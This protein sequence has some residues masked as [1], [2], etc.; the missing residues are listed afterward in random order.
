M[1]AVMGTGILLNGL[2]SVSISSRGAMADSGQRTIGADLAMEGPNA[3]SAGS[4]PFIEPPG[5]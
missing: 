4:D 1:T 3:P 2:P 5:L